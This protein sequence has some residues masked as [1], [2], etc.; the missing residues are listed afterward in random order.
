M[1]ERER[2]I[3]MIAYPAIALCWAHRLGEVLNEQK[4]IKVK[5]YGRKANSFFRY[6][7]DGIGNI[8]LNFHTRK[9]EYINI[10]WVFLQKITELI[11]LNFNIF[12]IDQKHNLSYSRL[13][14]TCQP[15]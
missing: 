15:A 5:N 14:K 13:A 3:K 6:S 12:K 1:V 2:I 11:G 7:F 10:L 9:Q 4:P 8:M